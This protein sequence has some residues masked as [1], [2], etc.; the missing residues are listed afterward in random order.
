[1]KYIHSDLAPQ[2]VGPYA[3]AVHAGA[4]VFCSGQIGLDPAKGELVA[5]GVREETKRAILNIEAVLKSAGLGLSDVVKT[6]VY[7]VH[8]DDFPEMNTVYETYFKDHTPAR[9]TVAVTA[10]PKNAQVEIACVAFYPS[11]T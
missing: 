1:M 8:M 2:A 11:H 7:L 10:L 3:Q 4:F 6:D 9:A 5:G